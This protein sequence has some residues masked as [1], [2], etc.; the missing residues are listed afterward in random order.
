MPQEVPYGK[1]TDSPLNGLNSNGIWTFYNDNETRE[2]MDS[3]ISL[4]L[5]RALRYRACSY[6]GDGQRVANEK[7][8]PVRC[9]VRVGSAQSEVHAFSFSKLLDTNYAYEFSLIDK[10]AIRAFTKRYYTTK[11]NR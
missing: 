9:K 8:L 6:D 5:G 10:S 11:A 2:G 7:V 3:L 4:H 1:L